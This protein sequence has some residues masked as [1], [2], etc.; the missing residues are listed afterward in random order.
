MVRA[1]QWR[2]AVKYLHQTNLEGE[3]IKSVDHSTNK[4]SV[5]QSAITSSCCLIYKSASFVQQ[6]LKEEMY[7]QIFRNVTLGTQ[8]TK[9][10]TNPRRIKNNNSGS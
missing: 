1:N 10:I 8:L 9:V 2:L 5:T 6:L 7:I 3:Q 4:H